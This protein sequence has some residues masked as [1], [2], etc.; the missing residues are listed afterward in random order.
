[1]TSLFDRAS[2]LALMEGTETRAAAFNNPTITV[3]KSFKRL[4]IFVVDSFSIIGTKI[5]LLHK[6]L[7]LIR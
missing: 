2:K 1:M 5:A 6:V 7:I 4:D 3:S